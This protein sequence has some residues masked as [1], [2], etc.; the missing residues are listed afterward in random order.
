[1]H[2]PLELDEAVLSRIVKSDVL[3]PAK[4]PMKVDLSNSRNMLDHSKVDMG[5]SADKWLKEL[6]CSK[7]HDVSERAIVQFRIEC[8]SFVQAVVSQL[9]EK[10]P[11]TYTVSWKLSCLCPKTC[12]LYTSPSPRDGL[13]SRM[14][15]SA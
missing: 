10:S 14:P 1:M 7:V 3:K 2:R 9:Q 5:F 12:L 6:V 13:L 8:R 15:S 4:D 11:L